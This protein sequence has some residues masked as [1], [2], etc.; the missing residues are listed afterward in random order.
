MP[1]PVVEFD[2]TPSEKHDPCRLTIVDRWGRQRAPAGPVR[3]T[4][5]SFDRLATV[6]R[7]LLDADRYEAAV[8]A[9]T[10]GTRYVLKR[11][12]RLDS[13]PRQRDRG[14]FKF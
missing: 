1:R 10:D 6:A 11:V 4:A 5:G 7:A 12:S 2:G 14:G 8:I 9:S 13:L 3:D